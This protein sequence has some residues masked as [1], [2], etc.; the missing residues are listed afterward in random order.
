MATTEAVFSNYHTTRAGSVQAL[1]E[2]CHRLSRPVEADKDGEP[3]FYEIA[4][5]W[6]CAPY[7]HEFVHQDGSRGARWTCPR[8]WRRLRSGESLYAHREPR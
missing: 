1:C 2:F 8:C 3:A 5:G 7:P 6:S 4:A